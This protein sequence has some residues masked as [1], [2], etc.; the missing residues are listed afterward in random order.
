MAMP[1]KGSRALV[2]D[3]HKYRWSVSFTEDDAG[4]NAQEMKA[5]LSI[6]IE[7]FQ[8]PKGMLCISFECGFA[9]GSS[10]ARPRSVNTGSEIQV[11][12]AQVAKWIREALEQ[13]WKPEEKADKVLVWL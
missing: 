12:P 1:R 9:Y 4:W 3:G 8:N 11:T 5:S 7:D 6:T 2:V 10:D 13:G